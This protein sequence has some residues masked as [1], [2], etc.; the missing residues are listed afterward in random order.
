MR[1]EKRKSR[2]ILILWILEISGDLCYDVREG[3]NMILFYEPMPKDTKTIEETVGKA[4]G[5]DNPAKIAGYSGAFLFDLPP[6]YLSPRL[7]EIFN[8]KPSISE[9]LSDILKRFRREDYGEVSDIEAENNH[10]QRWVF[11]SYVDMIGRYRTP[12]GLLI[13]ELSAEKGIV[14]LQGEYVEIGYEK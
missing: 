6:I 9:I 11:N 1:Q 13:V 14:Q 2:R 8:E 12:V 7:S 3:D 5:I 10:D 4:T